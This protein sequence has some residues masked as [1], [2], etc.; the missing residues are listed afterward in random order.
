M[1]VPDERVAELLKLVP[2]R[3]DFVAKN[4][5]KKKMD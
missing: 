4:F 1:R 3:R 5:E 2:V